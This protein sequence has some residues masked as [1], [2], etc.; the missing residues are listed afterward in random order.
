MISNVT[1][2]RDDDAAHEALQ[3]ASAARTS[4]TE[5]QK[6]LRGEGYLAMSDPD[7]TR[8][9]LRTRPLLQALNNLPWPKLPEDTSVLP[10]FYGPERR[11]VL[12]ELFGLQNGDCERLGLEIEPPFFCD[13]GRRVECPSLPVSFAYF[14]H[15]ASTSSSQVNTR[16]IA[17][18]T[19]LTIGAE[20]A[21]Y[22][23]FSCMILDCA[24]V[25]SR[26]SEAG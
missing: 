2:A 8:G 22:C 16:S 17:C 12:E 25:H 20:G 4:L 26:S 10:D 18:W 14:Y 3:Q 6:M 7:L 13:Y 15:R 24:Q 5:R 21:F 9:R 1:A 11:K 19:K 23:N